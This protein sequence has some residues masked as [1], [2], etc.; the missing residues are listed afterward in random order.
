MTIAEPDPTRI[1]FHDVGIIGIVRAGSVVTLVLEDVS[2]A[3]AQMAAEVKIDGVN[4]IL[5]NGLPVSDLR[6]EKKDGEVL[7][8]REE[9]GQILLAIQW[10]DFVAKTHEVVSYRLG[11]PTVRLRVTPST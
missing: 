8:L 6:M 9:N 11:G 3:G 4:T 10:D 1:S 7:T 2:I 5:R